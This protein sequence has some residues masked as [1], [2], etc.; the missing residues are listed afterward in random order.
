MIAPKAHSFD[1]RERPRHGER[2]AC[3][4]NRKRFNRELTIIGRA[5]R[6]SAGAGSRL[7][8]RPGPVAEPVQQHGR[9]PKVLARFQEIPSMELALRTGNDF[10]DLREEAEPVS[11]QD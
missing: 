2:E 10:L 3:S 1:A 4:A 6:R 11:L 9:N 8:V 7:S 5:R